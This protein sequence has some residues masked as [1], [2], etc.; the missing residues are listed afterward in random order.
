MNFHN[1]EYFSKIKSH[2]FHDIKLWSIIT[3]PLSYIYIYMHL[4]YFQNY[5]VSM[6]SQVDLTKLNHG[7]FS[8]QYYSLKYD[9][10]ATILFM[11]S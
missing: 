5:N 8:E 7:H 2:F 6:K 11:Y 3:N 10:F 9:I 1:E 4:R